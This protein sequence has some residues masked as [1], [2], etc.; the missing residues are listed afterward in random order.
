M[1]YL[2][3]QVVP[4]SVQLEKVGSNYIVR[5]SVPTGIR[6]I[7]PWYRVALI[8]GADVNVSDPVELAFAPPTIENTVTF[9]SPNLGAAP[10]VFARVTYTTRAGSGIRST[11]REDS[12][13]ITLA[14]T[15]PVITNVSDITT[16]GAVINWTGSDSNYD[17]QISVSSGF[18]SLL[19]NTNVNSTNYSV[20]GLLPW[21]IYY[22]RIRGVNGV[23]L[24]GWT[25]VEFRT[26]SD[27]VTVPTNFTLTHVTNTTPP[28]IRFDWTGA[29]NS[30][31][32]TPGSYHLHLYQITATQNPVIAGF[33]DS[34]SFLGT[35]TT[36]STTTTA[37]NV[38]FTAGTQ[39][40]ARVRA[41]RPSPPYY[42]IGSGS[43]VNAT[44]SVTATEWSTAS[45]LNTQYLPPTNLVI[46]N[47]TRTGV[48]VSW[49]PTA[50][51]VL[52]GSSFQYTVIA[53][54]G[55]TPVTQTTTGNSVTLSGLIPQSNYAIT[56]TVTDTTPQAAIRR[57]T[58]LSGTFTTQDLRLGLVTVN[59]TTP[60]RNSITFNVGYALSNISATGALSIYAVTRDAANTTTIRTDTFAVTGNP[61]NITVPG[62]SP[63]T[64]YTITF[65]MIAP[66]WGSNEIDGQETQTAASTNTGLPAGAL[67]YLP[68]TGNLTNEIANTLTF[69]DWITQ[70]TLP[71][72]YRAITWVPDRNS[73]PNSA[74]SFNSQ[75]WDF[76]T[77]S[78]G[79][80]WQGG[81]G[82]SQYPTIL[83][84]NDIIVR[85]AGTINANLINLNDDWTF[86]F[87]MNYAGE[88]SNQGFS[89]I[90]CLNGG[91]S[92]STIGVT[93]GD[94]SSVFFNN[95]NNSGIGGFQV[96]STSG[97]IPL[98]TWTHIAI[99]QTVVGADRTIRI[100]I[101]GS[102]N[103]SGPGGAGTP[104]TTSKEFF[105]GAL[106]T[107]INGYSYKGLLDGFLYS[108]VS[109]SGSDITDLMNNS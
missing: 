60:A 80:G 63:T 20:S 97:S 92:S 99:T 19:I 10:S 31:G 29:P 87:W 55:A 104:P 26:Q 47:V 57:S 1:P 41:W 86:S 82:W 62:L 68:F 32:V 18:T 7:R 4:D 49:T 44:D 12:N 48:T 70:T 94:V 108:P 89:T 88:V 24:S 96:S 79:S 77:T 13:V 39:W 98:N 58:A 73:N 91:W 103:A 75:G 16:T 69:S 84:L 65:K 67:I 59:S 8:N 83:K 25:G 64:A 36:A 34:M 101:N 9:T 23:S 61:M 81:L 17:V 93:R 45:Y 105:I 66:S 102:L 14:A 35:I 42:R 76:F 71:D 2:Q 30:N 22:A 28:G 100:Y 27:G 52:D 11:P 15:V 90:C 78:N 6:G 51:T 107:A 56:V 37:S 54:A 53:I 46:T 5:W 72:Q 21:R 38:A 95:S 40:V 109:Y 50:S 33:P 74:A 43:V 85:G 3:V 106:G